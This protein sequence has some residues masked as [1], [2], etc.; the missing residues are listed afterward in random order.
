MDWDHYPTDRGSQAHMQHRGGWEICTKRQRQ[1]HTQPLHR[2]EPV[3]DRFMGTCRDKRSHAT[4]IMHPIHEDRH[5]SIRDRSWNPTREIEPG[6][7]Q[8]LHR[9]TGIQGKPS[10]V[11]GWGSPGKD[12]GQS[13]RLFL[14]CLGWEETRGNKLP[15]PGPSLCAIPSLWGLPKLSQGLP[16]WPRD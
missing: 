14:K 11:A 8:N 9:L 2:R 6:R 15:A 1:E 5:L 7:A 12:P 10:Q 16:R 13:C 4:F 3:R